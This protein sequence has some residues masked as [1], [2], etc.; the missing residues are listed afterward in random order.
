M[1]RIRIDALALF[2]LTV[3]V[4][5]IASI[6]PAS[7]QRPRIIPKDGHTAPL[8][9]RVTYADGQ[10]RNLLLLGVGIAGYYSYLGEYFT[11][12]IH[13]KDEKGEVKPV[14]LD[15]IK[16]IKDTSANDALFTLADG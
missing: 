5:T 12:V 1:K 7:A 6:L 4:G 11:H 15:T 2:A 10:K 3:N 9:I 13:L 8:S 14:F 16:E